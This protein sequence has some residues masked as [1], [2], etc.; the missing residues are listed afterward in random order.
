MKIVCL[1][2]TFNNEDLIEK[3]IKCVQPYVDSIIICIGSVSITKQ[4]V[5]K[6]NTE[7]IVQQM[8]QQYNNIYIT[9]HKNEGKTREQKEGSVKTNM[10]KFAEQAEL[11]DND[12]WCF[13]VDSDEFYHEYEI[14]NLISLLKTKYANFDC[15]R[16][17]EWQFAYNLSLCFP[18]SHGRFVKYKKNSYVKSTHRLIW[19][20]GKSPW[21]GKSFTVD[22]NECMMYHLS[23]AQHPEKIRF[24][25]L[26]FNRPSLTQ[27]YN[28]VYLEFPDNPQQAY[29]NNSKILPYQGK[30]WAEGNSKPLQNNC[31]DKIPDI[32]QGFLEIEYLSYIQKNKKILKV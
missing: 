26:S 10:L 6:D 11:I 32:L 22:K 24:K 1:I 8:C 12:D 9:K 5:N 2:Q 30:G 16:I 28:T 29:L 23:Y 7:Q 20:N 27:W 25:V 17:N 31:P 14:E 18:S 4:N 3:C 15:G 13:T 19:P 21:Q